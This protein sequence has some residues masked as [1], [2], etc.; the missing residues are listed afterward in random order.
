MG[1]S[2]LVQPIQTRSNCMRSSVPGIGL[3]HSLSMAS[4]ISDLHPT[5][6]GRLEQGF[7]VEFSQHARANPL[8]DALF[9]KA[10]VQVQWAPSPEPQLFDRPMCSS[11]A[12][13]CLKIPTFQWLDLRLSMLEL[14]P[15]TAA[16]TTKC[17]FRQ[18]TS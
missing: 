18:R 16:N 9:A 1:A 7:A 2:V 12:L 3:M 17:R 13:P 11:C 10:Q 5:L 14:A 15:A 8:G 6:W 4:T